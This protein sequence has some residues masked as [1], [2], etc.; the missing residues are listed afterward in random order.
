MRLAGA[1]HLPSSDERCPAVLMMQG[2]GPADRD[3]DGY[4]PPIQEAFLERG[5]ATFAFDKP[6]CGESTGDWRD[7]G[8][9]ARADQ[10]LSA[11]EALRSEAGIDPQ[12]VGIWGQS[13][14]GWL[15][16]MLASR[17]PDLAFAIAN[18]GPSITVPEQ[19][20]YDCVHTL[21]SLGHSDDEVAKSV[22][23]VESLRSAA[24]R[25][26][27]FSTVEARFLEPVRQ[28]AVVPRRPC[29]RRRCGLEAGTTVPDRALRAQGSDGFDPVPVPGHLRGTRRAAPGLAMR[30]GDR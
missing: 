27:D 28:G 18:S 16:Q 20:V 7:Y 23:F 24:L 13:Q 1:L 22:A 4:F 30:P 29:N 12:R 21:R 2:S 19:I 9:E 25:G 8:L 6:G 5:I 10:A 11:L 26:M 17:L 14:G 3:S 15:V